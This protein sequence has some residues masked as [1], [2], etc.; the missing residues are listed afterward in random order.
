[1]SSI[2]LLLFRLYLG[3]T[4]LTHGWQ[5]I[6]GGFDATDF[7]QV[8]IKNLGVEGWWASFLESVALP[9][10]DLFNILVPWRAFLIG[11]GLILRYL[12]ITAT[13]FGAVM[14]FSF[15]FSE[16]ANL[17]ALMTL[18]AVF[19][20]VGG[21]NTGKFSVDRWVLPYIRQFMNKKSNDF[22]PCRT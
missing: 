10:I 21:A 6:S 9:N 17:N 15:L 22:F 2:L 18:L 14:N 3:Y 7:L 5:K 4:F 20:L 16:V 12:T 8:P 1:M 13:F 11:L 19:I